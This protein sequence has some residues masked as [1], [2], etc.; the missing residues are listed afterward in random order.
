VAALFD[1]L[2]AHTRFRWRLDNRRG[3]G[4]NKW[5]KIRRQDKSKSV[6]RRHLVLVRTFDLAFARFVHMRVIMMVPVQVRV[7]QRSVIV[8]IAITM[9]VLERRQNKGGHECQAAMD[10]ECSSHQPPPYQKG[11]SPA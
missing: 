7:D 10:R 1:K 11:H 8:M 9:D 6:E 4:R 5:R 3:S 2:E